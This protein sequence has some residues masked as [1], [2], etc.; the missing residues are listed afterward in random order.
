MMLIFISSSIPMDKEIRSLEFMMRINPSLQN[1]LHIPVYALLAIL[2][3]ISFSHVKYSIK[4]ISLFSFLIS[5]TYGVVDEV[6]Q[7]LIPGR[8]F[9]LSDILLDFIG[10]VLGCLLAIFLWKGRLKSFL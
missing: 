6:H 3:F 10:V 9:S 1:L 5:L 8:Y 4:M 2:W 7:V